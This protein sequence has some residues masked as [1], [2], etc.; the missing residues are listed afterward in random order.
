MYTYRMHVHMQVIKE[1]NVAKKTVV[2]PEDRNASI[3]ESGFPVPFTVEEFQRDVLTLY[4]QQVR[5][6][7]WMIGGT[8]DKL[9][10]L[11]RTLGKGLPELTDIYFPEYRV[12]ELELCWGDIVD[13]DFAQG[14][15]NLYQ[16]AYFG[17]YDASLDPMEYETVYTWFYALLVDFKGSAFLEE[18]ESYDGEGKHS[19]KRCLEVAELANARRMLETGKGF[20]Y[21]PSGGTTK[22]EGYLD[23]GQLTVRQMALLAG[24]EE[25]SIRAAANPKRANPLPTFSD[26]G[27]TRIT[28]DAA[29]AWLQSKGRY[30]PIRHQYQSGDI[31][32]AKRRFTGFDDLINVITDRQ[33]FLAA[34]SEKRG[35]PIGIRFGEL[36]AKHGCAWVDRK[37]FFNPEFVSDFADILEFPPALF[38]LRVREAL[39]KEEL[40]AVERTLRE[41]ALPSQ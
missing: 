35:H 11:L 19:A 6:M 7:A 33:L 1:I 41:M 21:L 13:T 14:L 26:E 39:A 28:I 3:Q 16:Y 31:D 27:R 12:E 25:M 17:I 2:P 18:W 9:P 22:D 34:D 29:K 30:V 32:L 40:A 15:H 20:S 24:M 36:E 5:A 23:D 37:A 10:L 38:A 8:S 4:V